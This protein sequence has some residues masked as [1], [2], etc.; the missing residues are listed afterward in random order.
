VFAVAAF[1]EAAGGFDVRLALTTGVLGAV[2]VAVLRARGR[3]GFLGGGAALSSCRGTE[4]VESSTAG[5]VAGLRRVAE[6][7]EA[8]PESGGASLHADCEL[9][10]A[11]VDD[12]RFFCDIYLCV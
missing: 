9:S 8:L 4:L 6:A 12:E 3:G 11:C 10:A 7:D 1:E 5:L 2:S